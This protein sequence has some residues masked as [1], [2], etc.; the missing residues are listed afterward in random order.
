[1]RPR[2]LYGVRCN[3]EIHTNCKTET[4]SDSTTSNAYLP[5]PPE[6]GKYKYRV[7]MYGAANTAAIIHRI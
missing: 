5:R 4:F 6:T 1:M 7:Q 2:L 3:F